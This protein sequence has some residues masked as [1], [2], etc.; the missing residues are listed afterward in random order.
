MTHEEANQ[1]TRE[2]LGGKKLQKGFKFKLTKGLIQNFLIQLSK[3]K[4]SK[5]KSK[6][7]PLKKKG[8]I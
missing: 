6:N 8:Q 2:I 4:P 7:I 5:K 3:F 1:K